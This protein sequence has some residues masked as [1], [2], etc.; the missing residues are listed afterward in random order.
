LA[1]ATRDA[2]R[3]LPLETEDADLEVF[4]EHDFDANAIRY[5]RILRDTVNSEPLP[6][7]QQKGEVIE[8]RAMTAEEREKAAQMP[9]GEM[10][11]VP[12]CSECQHPWSDADNPHQEGKGH[13]RKSGKCYWTDRETGVPCDCEAFMP[14]VPEAEQVETQGGEART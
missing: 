9:L 6:D 11:D 5:R 8:E 2:I 4:I 14:V 3:A 10:R 1:N 7:D 12:L 13:S